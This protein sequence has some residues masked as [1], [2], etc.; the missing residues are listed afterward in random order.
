MN[1]VRSIRQSSGQICYCCALFQFLHQKALIVADRLFASSVSCGE[2]E[3]QKKNTDG[4]TWI[5]V[6]LHTLNTLS[7][8]RNNKTTT[9]TIGKQKQPC[10]WVSHSFYCWKYCAATVCSPL[11]CEITNKWIKKKT[12]AKP[13]NLNVTKNGQT[14]IWCAP[15]FFFFFVVPFVSD[16]TH[17]FA[18][19]TQTGAEK[20]R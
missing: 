3:K 2:N 4:V 8:S 18:R 10:T 6:L 17:F 1:G 14:D 19:R 9:A 12:R 11:Q 5:G 16:V 7:D 13:C 20:K 15:V